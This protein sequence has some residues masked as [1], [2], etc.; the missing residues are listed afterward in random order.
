VIVLL[1]SNWS[2]HHPTYFK[3]FVAVL[4][5][6]G[7]VVRAICPRPDEVLEAMRLRGVP[8]GGLTVQRWNPPSVRV[9]PRRFAGQV[10]LLCANLW[11]IHQLKRIERESGEAINLVF[12]ACLS[13]GFLRGF[14]RAFRWPWAG[15]YLHVRAFRM[16]G[17]PLP[18]TTYVPDLRRFFRS[19]GLRGLGVLDEGALEYLKGVSGCQNVEVFPD[20]T[21]ESLPRC[22]GVA[23][24][25]R[26][27]AEGRP[28]VGLAGY[29]QPT[30]GIV[31]LARVADQVCDGDL[32][33]AFVGEMMQGVYTEEEER[34]FARVFTLPHV[35]TSFIRI[36][37]GP[38]FN[39]VLE[40]FDVIFA[41]YQNFPHSSNILTKAAFLRKPVVVSDGYLMAERVR[42]FA[43]G[44]I[45]QEGDSEGVAM[46]IQRLLR[47]DSIESERLMMTSYL[48]HHS[49][50]C[51]RAA[52]GRCIRNAEIQPASG[53]ESQSQSRS[54]V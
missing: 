39:G 19:P 27:F 13:D 46:A 18:Y 12:F 25:L 1:E 31:T 22:E 11:M 6:S 4:L 49:L 5:E 43:L 51:L 48:E 17:V 8:T 26:D 9:W 10:Q 40:Q 29:L 50:Q 24:S 30:K 33:F 45:V 35:F 16:P 28:I 53:E 3:E 37:D 32:V 20:L 7:S 14:P 41:A 2:G 44:E 15:L 42:R 47:V 54:N 23:A 52:M 36:P 34:L 38:L 21:D